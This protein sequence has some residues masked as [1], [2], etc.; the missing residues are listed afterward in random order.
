[1]KETS[2]KSS[3]KNEE[4]TG[5]LKTIKDMKLQLRANYSGTV[6][7]KVPRYIPNKYMKKDVDRLCG[8]LFQNEA[9]YS[10]NKMAKGVASSGLASQFKCKGEECLVYSAIHK[11]AGS[12]VSGRFQ[13]N[14]GRNGLQKPFS[15]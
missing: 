6:H 7:C 9:H 1:M 14:V 11:A 12:L 4:V 10:E 3:I 8:K 15:H 5:L 2:E 13:K